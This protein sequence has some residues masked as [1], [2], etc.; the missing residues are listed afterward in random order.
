MKHKQLTPQ[1]IRRQQRQDR[2]YAESGTLR[3]QLKRHS[4][5]IISLAVAVISLGYNTWR[6]ETS[7]LHRNW[8]QAAFQTTVELN[9]LQQIVLYRRYFHGREEHPY[10]PIRDAETWVTGWG[11][12]ASIRD[13]TS[14]LPEPLPARGQSLHATWEQ[15]AGDLDSGGQAAQRAEDELMGTIDDTRQAT[16]GLIEQLR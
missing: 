6:N 3:T 13:L 8:R 10:Q 4:V 12:V 15:H 2:R 14:V 11:K 5:A 9:E 16:I 1:R 7:E